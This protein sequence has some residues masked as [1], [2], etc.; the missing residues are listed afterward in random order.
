MATTKH[1]PGPEGARF[2]LA[3]KQLGG[4][5]TKVG[6]FASSKYPDG[7]PV[8]YVAAIQEFGYA[9]G[10]IPPRPTIRPTI[11]AQ[12][13]AWRNIMGQAVRGIPKGTRTAFDCMELLGL[14][15]AGDIRASIAALTS[16]ALKPATLAARRRRGNSS[17]KPLVDTRVLLPTLTHITEQ[18]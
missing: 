18:S 2:E 5:Q 17:T 10:G 3:M 4:L 6:W 13:G 15:A 9:Q 12:Q 11:E 1:V 8:A 14:Q 16:P 7:T